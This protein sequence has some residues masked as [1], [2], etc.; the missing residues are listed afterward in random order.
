MKVVAAFG[1]WKLPVATW[2]MVLYTAQPRAPDSHQQRAAAGSDVIES[3]LVAPD[4]RGRR[5]TPQRED[6]AR[7]KAPSAAQGRRLH[8]P[9]RP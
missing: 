1:E 4:D 5:V 3:R 8:C 9:P 2:I 7:Q 6:M